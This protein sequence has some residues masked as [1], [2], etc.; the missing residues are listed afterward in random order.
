MATTIMQYNACS[1][2]ARLIEFKQF[3]FNLQLK[4]DVICIQETYLKSSNKFEISGYTVIRKDRSDERRGG[5]IATLI[6]TG[7]NYKE[8]KTET[9]MECL[10][11]EIGSKINRLMIIN[12]YI[13]T[14]PEIDNKDYVHLMTGK[15]MVIEGA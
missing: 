3:L 11:F 2:K 13:L 4:P 15:N 10:L 7:M 8:Y 1:I 14:T 6:K 5:G 9:S 12:V